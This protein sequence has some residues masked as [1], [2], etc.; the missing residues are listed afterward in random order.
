MGDK[1]TKIDRK[2]DKR[3]EEIWHER[4]RSLE[5]NAAMVQSSLT[6]NKIAKN[7]VCH[8][9]EAFTYTLRVRYTYTYFARSG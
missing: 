5:A 1:I 3:R 7:Q 6:V 2:G 9:N 4:K 8:T